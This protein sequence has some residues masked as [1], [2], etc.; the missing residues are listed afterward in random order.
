M[1]SSPIV[2]YTQVQICKYKASHIIF[3]IYKTFLVYLFKVEYKVKV[4]RKKQ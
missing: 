3:S 4:S 2:L 1:S